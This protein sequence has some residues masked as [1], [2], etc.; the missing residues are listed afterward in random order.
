MDNSLINKLKWR[1]I[2]RSL[3]ELDLIF[4]TFINNQGLEQLSYNEISLYEQLININDND[5]LLIFNQ[6][7]KPNNQL[8]ELLVN[9]ILYIEQRT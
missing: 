6:K 3:L 5:L 4:Y 2:R 8:I 1:S 7:I 9:K